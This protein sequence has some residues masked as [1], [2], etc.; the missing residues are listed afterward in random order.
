MIEFDAIGIS[1]GQGEFI[2]RLMYSSV[3]GVLVCILARKGDR[4]K[5]C[6]VR[7][8]EKTLYAEASL[9]FEAVAFALC[10]SKIVAINQV[11]SLVNGKQLLCSFEPNGRMEKTVGEVTLGFTS[12]NTRRV[13][14]SQFVESDSSRLTCRFA[15]ELILE[16]GDVTVQ[17]AVGELN[18]DTGSIDL[19]KDLATPFA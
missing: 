19:I 15:R 2:E 3:N 12:P 7:S 11:E 17:Y 13:W 9:P 5:R 10:S 6:F 4:R 18:I 1:L 14:V 16:S 8:I